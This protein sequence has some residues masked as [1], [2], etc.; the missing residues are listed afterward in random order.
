M[1]WGGFLFRETKGE[2]FTALCVLGSTGL[3]PLCMENLP[4]GVFLRRTTAYNGGHAERRG[5]QTD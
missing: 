3:L 1:A 2:H 4:P 5:L